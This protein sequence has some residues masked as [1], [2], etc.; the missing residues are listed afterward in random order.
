MGMEAI[1]ARIKADTDTEVARI[2]DDAQE[3]SEATLEAARLE[4]EEV[5]ERTIAGGRRTTKASASRIISQAVMDARRMVREER[6]RGISLCFLEAE[7]EVNCR[8]QTPEYGRILQNLI[9]EGIDDLGADEGIIIPTERD[10]SLVGSLLSKD[11]ER[12]GK[13]VVNPEC[14][15]CTGGVV[16][17]SRNG[18]ITINNTFEGRI[19]RF[20]KDL[21]YA[22][23]QILYRED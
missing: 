19:G 3:R 17:R 14:V 15:L 12:Y 23:A 10:R 4:A 7:K 13:F 20:K 16:I 1:I 11:P 8:V 18:E 22:V 2:R 21:V 5:Y 9:K 6:E